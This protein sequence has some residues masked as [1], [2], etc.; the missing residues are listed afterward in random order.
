MAEVSR[1][2]RVIQNAK[3]ALFFYCINLILQFFSR[4]IFLDYLGA[5]LLGLNST[6]ANIMILLSLA[7]SGIGTAVAF[8]LYK[9]LS[10]KN[11]TEI[12]EIVSVQGWLY[13]KVALV[14]VLFSLILVPF[15]PIIFS[16]T[17]VS[18]FYAYI[19]FFTFLMC[20]ILG[21][22][23]NYKIVV[24]SADQKDYKITTE[25]QSI[26]C[27]KILVQV[28]AISQ[29]TCGYL[30]W[31]ILEI[32]AELLIAFRLH[33][34][35]K[36]E[37]PWLKTKIDK[38]DDFFRKYSYLLKKTKQIFF[39]RLSYLVVIQV[40]PLILYFYSSLTTVAIY[41]NY[42]LITNGCVMLIDALSRGLEAG[43]GNLVASSKAKHVNTVFWEIITIRLFLSAIVCNGIYFMASPLVRIWLGAEY[44]LD[45]NA[46]SILSLIFFLRM[47]RTSQIFLYAY[48]LVNDTWASVMEC[49]LLLLF[50]FLLGNTFGLHGVLFGI[51]ISQIVI[52]NSWK[53]YF[54][55]KKGFKQDVREYI[56]GYTG[57]I[58]LLLVGFMVTKTIVTNFVEL[59]MVTLI[60]WLLLSVIT[61]SVYICT[62]VIVFTICDSPFRRILRRLISLL[63]VK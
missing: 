28:L 12:N 36:N 23:V 27:V 13:R 5:E 63:I 31:L 10:T 38:G 21:Y 47:T 42:F 55:Y 15:F 53:P 54:L 50:S 40:T 30:G 56:W 29:T 51:L 24:L 7:E 6:I 58:L 37:Y 62:S 11:Q 34:V 49:L 43:I 20:A 35:I 44:V 22:V 3:V 18:L 17:E 52:S 4:K 60:D 46:V 32:I 48:G 57:K 41:S 9:P 25:S 16:E 59:P 39:Q 14:V 33:L 26:R 2:A 45:S 1:T 8:A 19:T 61:S